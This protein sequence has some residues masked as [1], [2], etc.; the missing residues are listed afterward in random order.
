MKK[1]R[2]FFAVCV[3]SIFSFATMYGQ[4]IAAAMETYNAGATALNA[5]NYTLAIE[6]FNKAITMF[7]S[8]GELDEQGTSTLKSCKEVLPQ[9]YLRYGKELAAKQEYGNAIAQLE[10]GIEI[11]KKY[12]NPEVAKEAGDLIPQLVMAE[13]NDNLNLGLFNEAIAGYNKALTY[14]PNDFD[15]YLRI[16]MAQTKLNNEDA[17]VAALTKAIELGEKENASKLL[18]TMYLKKAANA[19]SAKN[20][21]EAF[22]MAKKSNQYF[23]TAQGNQILGL[24]AM[25][26]KKYDDAIPALEA[27]LAQGD[28][29]KNKT[30]YLYSLGA[31]YEA[32][33]NNAKACG[34]YKQVVSD[35]KYKAAVE[36]KINNVL[37]CK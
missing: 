28:N 13:A 4:D 26:L 37:K 5:S 34:Y 24:S 22:A 10:K 3:L 21:A 30:S 7:E 33:G 8:L 16:G 20:N 6:S 23:E 9:I 12:I 35:P 36:Y 32:K 17:A 11:A 2:T 15:A 25:Q 18:S 14:N 27:Y 29:I 31:A 19:F 1:I